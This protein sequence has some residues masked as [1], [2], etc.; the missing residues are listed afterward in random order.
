MVLRFDRRVADYIR[1]KKWHES[2]ELKN[3]ADGGVELRMKLS[4]LPEVERWVLGWA[5]SAKV[6]APKELI[7][8]VQAS[9][10]RILASIQ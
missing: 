3:L 1:E 4:G 5:G 2:Q 8:A 9:A 7:E 10:R 6:L